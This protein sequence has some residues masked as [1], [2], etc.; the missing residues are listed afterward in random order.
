MP[1][2]AME[3]N[4]I[5]DD[6]LLK[7]NVITGEVWEIFQFGGNLGGDTQTIDWFSTPNTSSIRGLCTGG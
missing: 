2:G 5:A 6:A 3:N 7:L 1:K 4:C